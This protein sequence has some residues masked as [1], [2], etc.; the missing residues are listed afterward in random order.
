VASL[1]ERLD[2]REWMRVRLPMGG[3]MGGSISVVVE[4][5]DWSLV[6]TTTN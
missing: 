2:D 5:Y 3:P 4:E 1:P 6:V